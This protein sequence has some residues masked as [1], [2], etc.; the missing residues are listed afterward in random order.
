[1]L[2]P[3]PAKA[4][5]DPGG[6]GTYSVTTGYYNLGDTA[7]TVP[8]DSVDDFPTGVEVVGE[9]DY[10]TNISSLGAR[11]VVEIVHGDH[12]PCY[13]PATEATTTE[14]PCVPPYEPIPSYQGFHYLAQGLA[15]DGEV[16]VSISTNGIEAQENSY[17]TDG[18]IRARDELAEYTLGLLS[19]WNSS[20]SGPFASTFVG[21]LN[22][23]DV[24]LI[25]H[26]RGGGAV[27]GLVAY[28]A[29]QSP[30][31]G[32]KAVE[33]LS[34]F[35]DP[36]ADP[37]LASDVAGTPTLTME[38]YCDGDTPQDA[39]VA[40]QDLNRYPGDAAPTSLVWVMGGNHFFWDTVQTPNPYPPGLPSIQDDWNGHVPGGSSDPWCQTSASTRLT[41]T[42]QQAVALTYSRG[43]MDVNLLGDSSLTPYFQGSVAPPPSVNGAELFVSY[44]PPST[45]RLVVN[46]FSSSSSLTTNDLGQ[47]V[48]VDSGG[49]GVTMCGPGPTS[50]CVTGSN[51]AETT[52]PYCQ[53]PHTESGMVEQA[54]AQWSGTGTAIVDPLGSSYNLTGSTILLRV[55]VDFGVAQSNPDFGITLHDSGGHATSVPVSDAAQ[56]VTVPPGVTSYYTP[57]ETLQTVSLPASDFSG[58]DLTHVTSISIDFDQ[59]SVSGETTSGAVD[60]ADL[61]VT[62]LPSTGPALP[63]VPS[64]LLLAGVAGLFLGVT[65]WRR[66]SRARAFLHR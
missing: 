48:T 45:N 17:S 26:S 39:G 24:G 13:N 50:S 5:A 43:F 31:Y 34:P 41:P 12:V 53:Q 22:L 33:M 15:S 66:R 46:S 56:A 55:G 63:E 27:A 2:S 21:H 62:N 4:L 16:A 1:M 40:Y 14:W 10:P 30:S 23:N 20:S 61:M 49:G 9:V 3:T 38:S 59:T 28:N 32:I 52:T 8:T 25:G 36:A 64:P 42:G 58:V 51:P 7:Y 65:A 11:P 29:S 6:P 47:P 18:G 19:D 44:I 35:W 37:D 54:D 57:K 60:L